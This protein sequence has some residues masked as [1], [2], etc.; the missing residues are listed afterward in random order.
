[1]TSR[2]AGYRKSLEGW[3]KAGIKHVELTDAMLDEF[4]KT[5]TLA[6]AKNVLADLGL[7]PV[8]AAAV[9]PDLWIPGP[10]RAASLETWRRRCEQ[11]SAIG[12]QKIY[13]PSTTNRRVIAEDFKA[14]P[15]CIR[16]TGDIAR[17]FNLTAMIEFVRTS[18]H[19]ATLSTALKMIREAAHPNVR[20]MLDFFHF[21]SGMSKFEDLD[22]IRPGEIAHVHFQDILDT[23]R[24]LIDNNG[25]VIP[26]DGSAPIVSILKKLAEKQYSGALSVELFLM[27]LQ[28]GDPFDVATRIKQKCEA[29]M[30]QANV[31]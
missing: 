15:G 6:A 29:V 24:E 30:R 11:F 9:L 28:Q 12:L 4:L 25:R 3:A 22:M 13:C 18:T 26:G 19:L 1:N 10:A 31:L 8:C 16:E 20:P 27:A 2:G 23:P 7:R 14:T 21:W 17:Q 5:D